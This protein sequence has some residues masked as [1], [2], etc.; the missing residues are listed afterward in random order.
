M[1]TDIDSERSSGWDIRLQCTVCGFRKRRNRRDYGGM[2]AGENL[3][4]TLVTDCSNCTANL[5]R[6]GAD[7]LTKHFVDLID[8]KE[9]R[10]ELD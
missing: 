8:E 10:R 7:V 1:S 2:L 6:I 3:P 4:S 9:L 5:G